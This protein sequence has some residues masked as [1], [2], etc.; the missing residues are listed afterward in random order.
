MT[1][2]TTHSPFL[3]ARCRPDV[4]TNLISANVLRTEGVILDDLTDRLVI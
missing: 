1:E 2:V 3:N 4:P